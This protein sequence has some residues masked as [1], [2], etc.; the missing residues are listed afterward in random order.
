MAK[1]RTEITINTYRRI[2][3]KLRAL[4]L[5]KAN[6]FYHTFSIYIKA[7]ITYN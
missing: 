2:E 6:Y 7:G 5:Y 1:L 3:H 4:L